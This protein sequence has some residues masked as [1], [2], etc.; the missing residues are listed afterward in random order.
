MGI[1]VRKMVP[2][3]LDSVLEL[4]AGWNMRPREG[5]VEAERTGVEVEHSFVALD[6]DRIILVA[7]RFAAGQKV[8]VGGGGGPQW[9]TACR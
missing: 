8:S 9:P 3:D 6:G 4:L 2:E 5:D 1:V 7:C